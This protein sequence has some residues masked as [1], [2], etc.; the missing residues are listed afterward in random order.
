MAE[1]DT[2]VLVEDTEI[3]YGS[4]QAILNKRFGK[5]ACLSQLHST[6]ADTGAERKP[7]VCGSDRTECEETCENFLTML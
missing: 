6:T 5:E 1:M 2:H 3:S 4:C 7:H